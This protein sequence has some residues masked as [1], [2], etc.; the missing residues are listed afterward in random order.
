MVI[1]AMLTSVLCFFRGGCLYQG[2]RWEMFSHS[3][4][5]QGE[6]RPH[7]KR[8]QRSGKHCVCIVCLCRTLFFFLHYSLCLL[9]NNISSLRQISEN[10][11]SLQTEDGCMVP[12]DK[13]VLENS[14]F[15]RC[16]PAPDSCHYHQYGHKPCCTLTPDCKLPWNWRIRE[17]VLETRDWSLQP[18]SVSVRLSVLHWIW[19]EF[20]FMKSNFW[21]IVILLIYILIILKHF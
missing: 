8:N 15:L 4:D 1:C 9:E 16:V 20:V 10:V 2:L 6:S 11:F 18:H 7:R 21:A 12:H 5:A 17:G 3:G 19:A 14:L 13:E